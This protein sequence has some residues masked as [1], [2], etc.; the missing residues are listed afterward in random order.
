[1]VKTIKC[2]KCVKLQ[3]E[4]DMLG[5]LLSSAQPEEWD[6]DSLYEDAITGR[7]E[8]TGEIHEPDIPFARW[9]KKRYNLEVA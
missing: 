3:K 9:L 8:Y 5:R 4:I 2:K 6:L 7:D 1:M